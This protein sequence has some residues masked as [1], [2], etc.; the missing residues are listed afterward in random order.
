MSTFQGFP[1]DTVAFI[2][3]LA[4][5]NSKDWFEANRD[6]YEESYREPARAFVEAM[7]EPLATLSPELN[8]DPRNNGSILRIH[9]DVRFSKDKSPYH[10]YLRIIFWQGAG[11]S[12]GKSG[13][14][15][16]ISPGELFLGGG[17]HGF[18][19]EQ[20]KR[21]RSALENPAKSEALQKAIQKVKKAGHTLGEPHLK[22]IPNT[23][24]ADHPA[25]DLFRYKGLYAGIHSSLEPWLHGPE[26]SDKVMDRFKTV[27]PLQAWLAAHVTLF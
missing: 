19:P 14:Y 25:P 10:T 21:Y 26:I 6:R 1:K 20:L 15:F 5:N 9:R 4:A 13:L 18:D 24:P 23:I 16:G 17:M 22:K 8:A 27:R 2:T 3:E 7:A 11:K 12:K